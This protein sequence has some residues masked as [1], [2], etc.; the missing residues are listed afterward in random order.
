LCKG[1]GFGGDFFF[2]F[3]FGCAQALFGLHILHDSCHAEIGHSPKLWHVLGSTFDYLVGASYFSWIHQHVLGHH[4]YTNVRNA[5]PD[6][7]EGDVDFRRVSPYQPREWYH[8]FQHIYAPMLYCLLSVKYRVQDLDVFTKRMNGQIRVGPAPLFYLVSYFVGKSTF[9]LWRILLPLLFSPYSVGFNVV[10]FII[11]EV[12]HGYYLTLNFQVSHVASG[13]EFLATPP[14]PEAVP[15]INEDWAILQVR[16]TQ[17]YAHGDPITGYLSGGLNYQV[18]HHLF[19]SISQTYYPQ[20][21]PIVVQTCKEYGI[22]YT[23]LPNF[24]SAVW[25]HI[26]YLRE[27]GKSTAPVMKIPAYFTPSKSSKSKSKH[28]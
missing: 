7:G 9:V 18:V 2:A 28:A 25:S 14:P 5:D 3:L 16:T 23:V 6:L 17:D 8:R 1:I 19:P 15:E 10:L 11:T 13:L 21:A 12:I 26:S 27:M 24:F 22:K 20:I 4:V